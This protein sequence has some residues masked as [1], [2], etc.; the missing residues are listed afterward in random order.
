MARLLFVS[1]AL[2]GHL[3]W[4]GFL[5][6]AQ[7][8]QQMGHTVRWASGKPV[9]RMVEAA[10]IEFVGVPKT[11]WRWPP[12]PMPDDATPEEQARLRYTRALDTWLSEDLIAEAVPHLQAAIDAFQ[13]DV[14]ANEPFLSATGLAAEMAGVP[15]AVCGW[16]ASPPTT[17]DQLLPVQQALS[18]ESRG[19]IERLNTQFG[20]RGA[21][22]ADGATPTVQSPHLHVSYFSPAWHTGE[23]AFMAQTAFVGGTARLPEGPRPDWL[24]DLPDAP[25]VF[26]TLGSTF[27]GDLGFFALAAQA[28]AANGAIPLV[29]LGSHPL[30]AD[31]KERLKR[32][33][34]GGTRLL[35]WVDYDHV[36]PRCSLI[37]HHGGMGTTHAAILH[38]LPQLIVPHAADQRVQAN[39]AARATVGLHLTVRDAQQGQLKAGVRALLAD[40]PVAQKV[41][42][43][44]EGFAALGGAERAA[45]LL[46]EVA[47]GGSVLHAGDEGEQPLAP[48]PE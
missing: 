30:P 40:A 10:G 12:P 43:L 11:G 38:G 8:A 5:R 48:T 22:W 14:V 31:D 20:V 27:T 17:H 41:A 23:A 13:P 44:R 29:V 45:E 39:R 9:R 21:N 46:A 24:D 3:D 1:A 36:L 25:A 42:A 15:M 4:G 6:T 32:A 35:A 7:A 28:A 47:A 2:A 33:L 37:I 19:R 18:A 26:I 34:P 16:P